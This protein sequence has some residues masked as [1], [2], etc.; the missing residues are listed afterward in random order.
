VCRFFDTGSDE[1]L[2]ALGWPASKKR[3]GRK[4]REVMHSLKNSCLRERVCPLPLEGLPRNNK[5]KAMTLETDEFI[6]RFLVHVLPKG[7]RRIRHSGFLANACQA[8]KLAAIRA[9]LQ[10]PTPQPS[11]AANHADHR[12]RYAILTGHRIDQCPVCGEKMVELAP[13]PRSP[14]PPH[15]PYCDTS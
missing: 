2:L 4:S 10:A 12:E 3:Q 14:S 7:F 1:T 9:A 11:P 15:T 5:S 13:W 8:S 6:R